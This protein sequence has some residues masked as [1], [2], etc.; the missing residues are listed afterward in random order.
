MTLTSFSIIFARMKGDFEAYLKG[1]PHISRLNDN[2]EI[3]IL[4]SCTHHTSCDDIGRVKIP[5]ML[6]KFTDK[7]L[8]FTVVSG[9][10][11]IPQKEYS[12]VIQCGGC[13]VTRNQ[14]INRLKQLENS[15]PITNYGMALAYMNGIF[16]RATK[17]FYSFIL[18]IRQKHMFLFCIQDKKG[19]ICP[20][21]KTNTR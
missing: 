8:S 20:A 1:T 12:L 17:C 21:Y 10:S 13:M 7:N 3:L 2:D 19:Y 11:P 15:I 5:N 16:E 18:H 4:E 6:Q 9:L 14:L